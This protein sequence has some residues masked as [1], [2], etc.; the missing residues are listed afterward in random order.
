MPLPVD[1][2]SFQERMVGSLFILGD[3]GWGCVKG[4]EGS[5]ESS[6]KIASALIHLVF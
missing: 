3:K 6:L 1:S 4:V 2:C 5:K